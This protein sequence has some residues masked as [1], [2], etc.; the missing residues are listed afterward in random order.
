MRSPMKIDKTVIKE[1]RSIT[2]G[3]VC[4]CA[5]MLTVFYFIT[6]LNAKIL[7][8]AIASSAVAILN[9]FLIG[10]TVQK[11]LNS[12]TEDQ[13]RLMKISQTVRLMAIALVIIVFIA[14]A[15]LDPFA[16]LIP[17]LF[18]RITILFRTVFL[19]V[20]GK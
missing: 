6:G 1:T 2:V 7:I 17:L 19:K 4:L 13:T 11:A 18:P 10:L 3:Q 5:V 12:S 9:Y 15:K 14:I 16:T 8:G 20:Q